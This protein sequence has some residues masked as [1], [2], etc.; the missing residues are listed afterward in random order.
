[1]NQPNLAYA[2]D[3]ATA[4]E[5]DLAENEAVP[6]EYTEAFWE[7][8]EMLDPPISLEEEVRR[9]EEHYARTGLHITWEEC[10]AWL[11][12]WGTPESTEPPECHT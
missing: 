9:S 5:V 8:A 4:D 7:E 3:V 1:M 10:E 2:D 6:V 12:T 11:K